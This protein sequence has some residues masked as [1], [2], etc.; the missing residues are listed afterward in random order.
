VLEKLKLEVVDLV[1]SVPNLECTAAFAME[2]EK[3]LGHIE[4]NRK[5]KVSKS[6]FAEDTFLLDLK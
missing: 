5:V 6:C 1:E 4:E 2:V 3:R